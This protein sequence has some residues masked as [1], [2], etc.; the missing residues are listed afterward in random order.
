MST[1]HQFGKNYMVYWLSVFFL[2]R[3]MECRRGLAMRILSV[4]LSN[5]CIEIKRK[6]DL[7]RSVCDSRASFCIEL[8]DNSLICDS[9]LSVTV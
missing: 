6:K 4:C 1:S 9:S 5:A 7:S 8:L 2:P 3:G